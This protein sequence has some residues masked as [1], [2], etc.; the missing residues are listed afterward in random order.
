MTRRC[1]FTPRKQAFAAP[2]QGHKRIIFN[3]TGTAKAASVFNLNIEALL[4]H[5]ATR[6]KFDGP[7]AAL[8]ICELKEPTISFPND[9]ADPANLTKTTK[10]QRKYNHTHDQQK[11]WDE[12]TQK[13]YN[14][15][16][17]HSTPKMKM[18]LLTMELWEAMS[19]AQDGIRAQ[20]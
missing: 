10:W 13:I 6:L 15:V 7:L 9:P 18:K 14:L 16:M 17:Q 20:K 1:S 2:T 5:I 12:N 19:A 8:A 11:W 3:N 4:E